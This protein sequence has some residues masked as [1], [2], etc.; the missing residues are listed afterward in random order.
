MDV[1]FILSIKKDNLGVLI[2]LFSNTL[3]RISDSKIKLVIRRIF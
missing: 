2:D 1:D 3:L